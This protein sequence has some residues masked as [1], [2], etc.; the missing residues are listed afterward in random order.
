MSGRKHALSA[1]SQAATESLI[2][3]KKVKG[4]DMYMQ[5]WAIT[6]K[7]EECQD[8][9]ADSDYA[10]QEH[11]CDGSPWST[12]KYKHLS[13]Q[14]SSTVHDGYAQH[15]KDTGDCILMIY[16]VLVS[17]SWNMPRVFI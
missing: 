14:S 3:M 7:P 6:S 1:E 13:R 4:N 17:I 9:E 10:I 2:K 15:D 12:F 16:I 5:P 8:M 11:R